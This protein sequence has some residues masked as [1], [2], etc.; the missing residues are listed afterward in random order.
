MSL[1]HNKPLKKARRLEPGHS[2]LFKTS[3]CIIDLVEHHDFNL[4]R[5]S[6][7]VEFPLERLNEAIRALAKKTALRR[8]Y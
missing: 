3:Q 8:G 2:F 6:L 7:F 4:R 5:I 1:S